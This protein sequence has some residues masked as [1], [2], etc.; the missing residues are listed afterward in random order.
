MSLF[1]KYVPTA[2]SGGGGGSGTVTSVALEDDS[3]TPIYTVGGSPVTTDGTLTLTLNVQDAN[4]VFAGPTTGADAQ[5]TF[6]VLVVDDL[7]TGN[8]T[9]AGTDG[10]TVTSGTDAVIGAGT[11]IQQQV[12]NGSQNGYLSSSDW[13]TFNSKQSTVSFGTFGSTPNANGGGISAGVI[14]LQ[15][16]DGSNPGGVSTGA[17]SFAGIKTFGSAIYA[18][19]GVDVAATGG[20]DTLSIGTANADVINIG[21]SGITVNIQGTTLYENVSQLQV[22]DP[23]ITINK[24]GG[25][26]SGANSG[27]EVEES[28]S[29]TAYVETSSDR[30]SWQFKAPNTAGVVT[31]TPGSSGFVIDQASHNPVT[32]G[33]FGS[34][35]NSSGASLSTQVLTLQPA[36]ATN[37]GGVSTGSQTFGG[38][39]TFANIIDSGLTASQAV[40]TDG[41]KQ[42]A[43]LGYATASTATTLAER[44]ASGYLAS[45]GLTVDG[46]SSGT[47]SILP[48]AAAGTFNFNLPTS[49]GTAGQPLLSGGGGS[50]PHTYGTLGVGAGGSGNTTFTAYSVLCAGTTST[51]AFQNVSGLGSAGQVLTSNGAGTLPTF[52]ASTATFVAPTVQKFTSGSGTYT[53]P[54]SPRAPLYIKVRMVG[55]GG[56]GGGSGTIA[57]TPGSAAGNGGNTTFGTTLLVANGG[58]GAS[59]WVQNSNSGLGGTGGTASLGTG[60]IGTA[61]QGGAGQ[62]GGQDV[63]ASGLN[64]GQGAASPFGGVG[65]GGAANANQTGVAAIANSGSGGGGA[66]AGSSSFGGAGGGS[67]GFVDAVI[68]S[69]DATYSYAV[70]AAGTAGAAGTSGSAGGAGGSG[71]IEVTE[72]YQ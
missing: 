62:G 40:V 31:L 13:T 64:G 65:A 16:A 72:H 26:G 59:N 22:T 35:P 46:S 3:S 23:L 30:N 54:S 9:A 70:G 48:Q 11:S 44:D 24:G 18:A 17:Q 53:L 4:K 49:A 58:N 60:P 14:T 6:R 20:T 12:A 10:I 25:A 66:G 47:V 7:P 21:R 39:K 1:V 61:I 71:Y 51:G 42:L 28:S 36:D 45:K 33:A 43:S 2:I 67:G 37:P 52:Q 55:G 32:L 50:N 19:G 34:S 8:L 38:T 56:G 41:S 29:I 69:P 5:P 15:P 68:N 27:I 57:G 63:A